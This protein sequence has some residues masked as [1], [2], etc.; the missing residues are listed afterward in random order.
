MKKIKFLC[1]VGIALMLG[2]P[3]VINAQGLISH[4][5][6]DGDMG[7]FVDCTTKDPNYAKVVNNR[8]RTYWIE[9]SY[10]GTRMTKGAEA[11]GD[12]SANG[13]G[14]LTIKH[15]WLGFVMNIDEDYMVNNDTE[16]GLMQ[17][18][19]FDESLGHSS[20]TAMLDFKYGNLTWTDRR[21]IGSVRAD[22]ILYE[23]YPKGVDMNIIVHAVLSDNDN[24]QVEI[25]VNGQLLYSAYNIDIGMGEFSSDDEQD[26]D[27]YTEFKIGQYDYANEG[28]TDDEVRIVDYD[29]I[30][31]YDGEDGYDMV[32]PSEDDECSGFEA[33][34][35]IE[36]EDYCD[37]YGIQSETCDEGGEDI[38]YIQNGDWIKFNDVDFSYGASIFEAR[39]ASA[40]SGGNI[41]LRLGSTT[42]TLIGTCAVSGTDNWQSWE[43]VSCDVSGASGINDLYL[44]FTGG[45]SY[46]FNINWIEFS[47]GTVNLALNGT[48]SQSSTGHSAPASRA[49]DGETSGEWS[50]SSV[51]HTNTE[52]NPWWQVDLG[53]TYS[54]D[55]IQIW[56]RTDCCMERLTNFTVSVI[57]SSGSTTF[58]ESYSSYPD[59]SV[60]VDAEGASGQIVQIQLD[61]SNPI[62]LAEVQVFGSEVALSTKS[63]SESDK[64][65]GRSISSETENIIYIYPNPVTSIFNIKMSTLQES[66]VNI[67]NC[68]GQIVK[69]ENISTMQSTID[70]N[71]IPSGLYIIQIVSDNQM[72]SKRIIK[73]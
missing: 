46:L 3:S 38:G 25:F 70:V 27:S 29:N 41:E 55:Y 42:G 66:Q 10:D 15:C 23:D 7:P 1:I 33:L 49:I 73:K 50:S 4:N 40:N 30:S 45:S 71:D 26:W 57:N 68:T 39:V 34:S 58:S 9:S 64:N 14:Y 43:T 63:T 72:Y 18:F 31:W 19:G 11:C 36:A 24:G 2:F 32:N 53:S 51:T 17:I 60:S 8:L 37:Q 67:I 28:Y 56:N 52:D 21:G 65:I 69:S 5:F 6:D 12:P 47:G 44:V 16:A 13:I 54:I 61:D 48:A 62:S 35:T 20:W 59:A 22:V